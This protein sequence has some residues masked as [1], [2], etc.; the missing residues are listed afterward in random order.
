VATTA[1][2]ERPAKLVAPA[3]PGELEEVLR[4]QLEQV[5]FLIP[6]ATLHRQVEWAAAERPAARRRQAMAELAVLVATAA[7]LGK[8]KSHAADWEQR[9]AVYLPV[10]ISFPRAVRQVAAAMAGAEEMPRPVEPAAPAAKAA[11]AET[12]VL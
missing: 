9:Q 11:T 2:T 4:L 7:Q 6:Q 5:D 3:V 1:K 12:A 8:L 10:A